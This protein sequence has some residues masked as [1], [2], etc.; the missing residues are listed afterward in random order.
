MKSTVTI[1]LLLLAAWMGASQYVWL[2]LV[3]DHCDSGASPPAITSADTG[4]NTPDS[5]PLP[6]D[7]GVS[8]EDLS[9]AGQARTPVPDSLPSQAPPPAAG[10][11]GIPVAGTETQPARRQPGMTQALVLTLDGQEALRLPQVPR[12]DPGRWELGA[13]PQW[14]DTLGRWLREHPRVDL[15]V[16]GEFR[17][18][19]LNASDWSDLGMAR[20]GELFDY[21]VAQGIGKNRLDVQSVL[22]TEGQPGLRL[23]GRDYA[24]LFE[25]LR[26]YFPSN[27]ARIPANDA[28][29]HYARLVG[30]YME[31]HPAALVRV[32]GHTDNSGP[33]QGNY[34]LG[35]NRAREVASLLASMGVSP[36]RIEV[37]S[38]GESSPEADNTESSGRALNRRVQLQLI[39]R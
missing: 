15:T 18:D 34:A 1:L 31:R 25:P 39:S 32:T 14:V 27:S 22:I 23:T 19:E 38:A 35:L 20:G 33:L 7:P 28:L 4:D 10:N 30:A 11:A 24:S 3:K 12:F 13:Q 16:T 37:T 29:E 9:A 6:I 26:I 21:L 2:C 8:G 5:E 36:A 17:D